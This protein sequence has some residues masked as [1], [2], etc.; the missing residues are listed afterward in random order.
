MPHQ[1]APKQQHLHFSGQLC[2]R[3]ARLLWK[4]ALAQTLRGNTWTLCVNGAPLGVL[5]RACRA[6]LQPQPQQHSTAAPP[7]VSTH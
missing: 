3:R 6:Q 5:L 1:Q 4:E 2:V 7:D